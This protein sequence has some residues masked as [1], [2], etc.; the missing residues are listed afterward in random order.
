MALQN[1]LI[2]APVTEGKGSKVAGAMPVVGKEQGD[3]KGRPYDS[4]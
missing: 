1:P 4:R 3:H 2:P